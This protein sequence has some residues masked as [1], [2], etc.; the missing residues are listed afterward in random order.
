MPDKG[1]ERPDFRSS[2][3]SAGSALTPLRPA[4][5]SPTALTV[6]SRPQ[7]VPS[8]PSKISSPIR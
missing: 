7:K 1:L 8:R 3:I 4:I 5:V 6:V 2:N